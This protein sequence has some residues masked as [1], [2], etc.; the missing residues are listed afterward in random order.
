MKKTTRKKT[1]KKEAVK[2]AAAK[3]EAAKKTVYKVKDFRKFSLVE[4]NGDEMAAICNA[5]SWVVQNPPKYNIGK[6][7]N[8]EKLKRQFVNNL[9][10]F[11][12]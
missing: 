3:K 10:K 1:V 2:K 8:Y 12:N 5:L 11:V 9:Q 7:S 6:I 4:L